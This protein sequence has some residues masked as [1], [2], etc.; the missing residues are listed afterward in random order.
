MVGAEGFE[1]S[2]PSGHYTVFFVEFKGKPNQNQRFPNF[3]G[4]PFFPYSLTSG[5][6]SARNWYHWY[7]PSFESSAQNHAIASC[8]VSWALLTNAWSRTKRAT[9]RAIA[10]VRN[11]FGLVAGLFVS[12]IRV[13]AADPR[14]R[15]MDAGYQTVTATT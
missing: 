14:D 12:R 6:Y 9:E 13:V 15:V 1:L 4:V 7:H 3:S 2:F 10:L 8:S 11:E 5:P